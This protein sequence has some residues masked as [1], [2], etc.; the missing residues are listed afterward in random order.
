M[1]VYI[2]IAI[3]AAI[4]LCISSLSGVSAYYVYHSTPVTTSP[5]LPLL[6]QTP[7]KRVKVTTL[8]PIKYRPFIHQKSEYCLDS[9]GSTISM[10][11][12]TST[13]SQQWGIQTSPDA[14]SSTII[15]NYSKKCLTS[16]GDSFK[17]QD[18]TNTNPSWVYNN[19]KIQF[20][21]PID[22]SISKCIDSD[23]EQVYIGDINTSD[24]QLWKY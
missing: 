2:I 21:D 7:K 1:E 13:G 9:D 14:Q 19:N 4:L 20:I 11:P 22:G 12:C 16:D 24:F 18:C 15:H 5:P 6:T 8:P 3:I 10:S 17:M 23:G